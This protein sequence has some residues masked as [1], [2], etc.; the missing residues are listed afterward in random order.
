MQG[1]KSFEI[2]KQLVWEA[3]LKVRSNQGSSGIDGVT[4]ARFER[5]L[6]NNLYTIWNRM[7]SGSYQPAPVKLVEIPKSGGQG[8]RPLGIPTVSDR[9][10]QMVV[11]LVLEPIVEPIFHKDSYG[12]RP[13]RSAHQAL[14]QSRKRCWQYDWVLDMDIKAFFDNID[15]DKLLSALRR[16]TDQKW[17]MLYIER[18]LKVSYQT[19]SGECIRRNKGVPQGSV[20][21]PLLSNLFLH[22][23][24]DEWMRRNFPGI[25]FE[26]YADDSICH[27]QT[28]RQAELLKKA[29]QERFTNCGLEL[30]ES[31]TRIV[32]CKDYKRKIVYG[33]ISFDFL[34]YTFRPRS[35]KRRDGKCF[36]GFTPAISNKA[37]KRI[38]ERLRL[39]KVREWTLLRLEEIALKINPVVQGW[40]SYYGKFYPSALRKVLYRLNIHLA[41]WVR[42][43]FKRYWHKTTRS[44]HWLG[45]VAKVRPELFAHWKWGV[46]PT[47]G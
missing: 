41:R 7:S 39:W 6:K 1:A 28:E 15:H 31:K 3:Y 24:F 34:G 43:K 22:Y 11:V 23:A 42:R 37:V 16:H 2:S 4:I 13:G 35:V 27:C 10:A 19:A 26:R 45:K 18:W 29:I 46:K 30:N 44:I 8:T 17:V 47:A 21:G 12:Y 14:D 33:S 20:I 9:I 40:I 36:T 38:G 25:P 5:D 32:Y